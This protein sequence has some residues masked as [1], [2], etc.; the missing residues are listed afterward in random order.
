MEPLEPISFETVSQMVKVCLHNIFTGDRDA[1]ILFVC[2]IQ[3]PG[4][5]NFFPSI[6]MILTRQ[7][8]IFSSGRGKGVNHAPS[9]L[10]SYQNEH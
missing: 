4:P 3:V 10:A 6:W 7:E 8:G 2:W 1:A 9:I 5:M